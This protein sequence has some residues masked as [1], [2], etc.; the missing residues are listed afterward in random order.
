MV[1]KDM[2]RIVGLLTRLIGPEP[3]DWVLDVLVTAAILIVTAR[4]WSWFMHG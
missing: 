3:E 4:V 1:V 2:R